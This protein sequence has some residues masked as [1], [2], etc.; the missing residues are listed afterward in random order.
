MISYPYHIAIWLVFHSIWSWK[1]S[2]YLY[3]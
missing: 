2:S 3:F 1:F